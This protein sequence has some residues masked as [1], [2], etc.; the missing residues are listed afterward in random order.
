MQGKGDY[1][2]N[3]NVEQFRDAFKY[4]VTDKLFLQSKGSNCK[5]DSD[6]ILLDVTN[7]VMAEYRKPLPVV[8]ERPLTTDITMV[9]QPRTSIPVQGVGA[10]LAGYLLR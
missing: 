3:P 1:K 2:D 4:V 9:I 6:K 10:Y 7:V 8:L 5:V